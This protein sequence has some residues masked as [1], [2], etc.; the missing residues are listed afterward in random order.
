MYFRYG[1]YGIS[2]LNDG[3]GE[4]ILWVSLQESF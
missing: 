3:G 2:Y 4:M 1:A